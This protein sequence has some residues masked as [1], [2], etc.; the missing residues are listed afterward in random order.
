MDAEQNVPALQEPKPPIWLELDDIPI[1]SFFI[2]V[3][4]IFV[5]GMYSNLNYLFVISGIVAYC[6]CLLCAVL[7]LQANK[8]KADAEDAISGHVEEEKF[9]KGTFVMGIIAILFGSVPT[10]LGV[11]MAYPSISMTDNILNSSGLDIAGT[12]FGGLF[13]ASI[14]LGIILIGLVC[15]WEYINQK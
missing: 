2:L 1:G 8:R 6:A 4:A 15:I 14:G 3:A 5:A 10:T 7:F 12:T 13:V 9:G 11:L